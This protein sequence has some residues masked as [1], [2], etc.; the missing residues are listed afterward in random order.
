MD[1]E[2]RQKFM[3]EYIKK[4]AVQMAVPASTDLQDVI[5]L[6]EKSNKEG[7]NICVVFQGV[8]LYALLDSEEDCYQKLY[9][10]TKK[11]FEEEERQEMLPWAEKRAK[12]DDRF[13]HDIDDV[14]K[15]LTAKKR[16]GENIY[17]LFKTY[18]KSFKFYS[19]AFTEDYIYLQVTG[20]TKQEYDDFH[21][22]VDALKEASKGIIRVEDEVKWLGYIINSMEDPIRK[23]K[24]ARL[25]LKVIKLLKKGHTQEAHSVMSEAD[26]EFIFACS[27]VLK[28]TE[29]GREFYKEEMKRIGIPITDKEIDAMLKNSDN[30]QAND[31]AKD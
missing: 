5:E 11:E 31:Q 21:E 8:K 26:R 1:K 20:Q 10:L 12:Y 22:K 18:N 24:D 6:F 23:G 17:V 28:F 25:A 4:T 19:Q 7:E 29:G 14:I 16:E 30:D 9:G 15:Y 13:C 3:E 2:T 27:A